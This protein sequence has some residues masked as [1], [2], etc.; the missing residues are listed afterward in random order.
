VRGGGKHEGAASAQNALFPITRKRNRKH[1]IRSI[2]PLVRISLAAFVLGAA[3]A[4]RADAITDA[5][6]NAA[7]AAVAACLA[8]DGN[9][10]HESRLYAMVH[11]AAHDAVNAIHRRSHPYAYQAVAEAGTSAE[12][13]VAAAAHDVLVS[14]IPLAFV[15]PEC[16]NAG[17][18]RAEADYARALAK[19]ANGPAK[20]KG[21][22]LGK[23]AAAAT[24]ARRANDGSTAPVVDPNFPQGTRP[25]QWRFTPG[26]PPI[27]FASHWGEVKP[28]ALK[29]AAQFRPGPPLAVSCADN[30]HDCR[31]YAADLEEVRRL[32][33]DG[34]SAPSARTPEQTEI[35]IFWM[36]S[37]PLAWNRIARNVSAAQGLDLVA[38][39]RLFALLNVAQADGYVASWATKFQYRFWRP[40]TA[41]REGDNDGNPGTTGDAGWMSLRPTPPVPDYESAHAVQGGAA[42]QVM[43]RVF[44]RDSIAFSN[45]SRTLPAG[46]TCDDPNPVWRKFRSFDEAAAENGDSRVYIGFHFRDAVEKGLK[47]GEQIGQWVV[48]HALEH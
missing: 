44:G 25:G 1:M 39:A 42:A 36:E 29:D 20:D 2:H 27:A 12:S 38:N 4:A 32:G 31:R 22:A 26:S 15:P 34:V 47:H 6:A 18:A 5:N 43:K 14:Q 30:A 3:V 35:A 13:A 28:F 21:I 45:C 46:S 40:V 41:V 24:I 9:P 16:A 23:A 48:D 10:L 8:P 17:I 11:L 33:S 19:I 7:A 37:S